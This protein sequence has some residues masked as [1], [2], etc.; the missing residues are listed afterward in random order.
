MAAAH[1]RILEAATPILSPTQLEQLSSLLQ[2]E[3]DEQSQRQTFF[4][5][6]MPSAPPVMLPSRP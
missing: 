4:R 5:G 6:W 3:S 1:E 2:Q